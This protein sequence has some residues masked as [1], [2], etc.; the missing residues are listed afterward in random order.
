MSKSIIFK[1]LSFCVFGAEFLTNL[2][3][4]F[5]NSTTGEYLYRKIASEFHC[6]R[7]CLLP[8]SMFVVVSR[9]NYEIKFRETTTNIADGN[10]NCM[11]N[12]DR[13]IYPYTKRHQN[14]KVRSV[15]GS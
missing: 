3:I 6:R 2:V 4:F 14:S 13:D 5:T 7:Q 9:N 12:F 1:P 11:H 15:F 8:T 10:E